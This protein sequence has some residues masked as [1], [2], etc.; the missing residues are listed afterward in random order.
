MALQSMTG[1]AR[2]QGQSG[3]YA[4]GWEIKSVNA[5]GLDVRLRVPIGWDAVEAPVRAKASETL[6]RGTV[7]ATLSV[8]RQGVAPTV[9]VNE[10][11]LDS[12]LGVATDLAARLKTSPPSVEGLLALKGVLEVSEQEE[13]PEERARAEGEIVAGFGRALKDLAQAR[14]DEGAALGRVL[15]ARLEEIGALAERADKAPGRKPEAVKA[16]LH[17]AR[18]LLRDYLAGGE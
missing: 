16:R 3:P 10:R 18:A 2:V 7:Y 4:W 15:N 6:S 5:K 13:R 17:R 9:R 11:V 1:F 14:R 8:E 12:V